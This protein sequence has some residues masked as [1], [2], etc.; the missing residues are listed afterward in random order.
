MHL[1]GLPFQ[2]AEEINFELETNILSS[3]R[4]DPDK[5]PG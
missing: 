4:K 1:A 3:V 2:R 5:M